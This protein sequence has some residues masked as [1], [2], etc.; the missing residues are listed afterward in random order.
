[1]PRRAIAISSCISARLPT[2]EPLMC[3]AFIASSAGD[4]GVAPPYRPTQ[5]SRPALRTAAKPNAKL[6][7]A[8]TKSIAAATPPPVAFSSALPAPSALGSITS[9]APAS[10]ARSHLPRS[11]SATMGRAPNPSF[12]SRMPDSPTP[13]APMINSGSSGAS[14]AHFFSALQAV[15]PEHAQVQACSS[16]SGSKASRYFASGTITWSAKPP[17]RCTPRAR[18]ALHRCSLP[19]RHSAQAP[20]PIHG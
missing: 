8:P 3:S 7:P 15:R 12:A 4:T 11:I 20:Q 16:G 9:A 5:T 2:Y 18:P 10:R 13:P 14:G 19:A 1:M 6:A 17:S